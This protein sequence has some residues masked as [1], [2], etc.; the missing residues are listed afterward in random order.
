MR[1]G[2]KHH[3]S[4]AVFDQM[5]IRRN[6]NRSPRRNQHIKPG[7]SIAG[8]SHTAVQDVKAI[9]VSRRGFHLCAKRA[10]GAQLSQKYQDLRREKPFEWPHAKRPLKGWTSTLS[11][12][13]SDGPPAATYLLSASECQAAYS[14]PTT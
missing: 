6:V 13:T 11:T 7:L 3:P 4:V 8:M 10:P 5:G 14:N 12:A 1:A 2:V 9:C